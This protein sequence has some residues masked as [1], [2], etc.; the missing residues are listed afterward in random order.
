VTPP[1][2]GPEKLRGTW[3]RAHAAGLVSAAYDELD[4]LARWAEIRSRIADPSL[5]EAT[6]GELRELLPHAYRELKAWSRE[7]VKQ[8]PR[9][10]RLRAMNP[11][12]PTDVLVLVA[13]IRRPCARSREHRAPRRATA[14]AGPSGG[15]DGPSSSSDP[16]LGGRHGVGRPVGVQG[17]SVPR[18]PAPQARAV[19]HGG[20]R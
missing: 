15:D 2:T 10:R 1:P 14:R 12:R 9:L 8:N 5:D 19:A 17:F 16:P 6:R 7:K 3:A 11:W 4:P 18:L 13:P 20:R